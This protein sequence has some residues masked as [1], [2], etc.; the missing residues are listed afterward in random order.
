MNIV[1]RNQ[2]HAN[3]PRNF[4]QR[5]HALA[6][7]LHPV[8]VQFDE[9]IFRAENVPIIGR[10]LF[11]FLDVVCLN[12]GV[13]FTLE[14]DTQPDQSF[15]VRGEQLLV[16]PGRVMKPFEVRGRH[17]LDEI[18]VADLVFRQQSEMIG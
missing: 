12:C 11:R 18:L 5:C 7:F 1:C 6:L 13:D 16:D 9:E 8:I 2:S 17:Q 15:R 3:V 4:R 10:A 14:T